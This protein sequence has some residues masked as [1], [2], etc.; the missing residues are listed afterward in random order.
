MLLL[1]NLFS[2]TSTFTLIKYVHNQIN[3]WCF[4]FCEQPSGS[5]H[6]SFFIRLFIALFVA[7][8]VPE[9]KTTLVLY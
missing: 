8:F 9:V 5:F 3:F 6:C 2:V 1:P 4:D 7:N